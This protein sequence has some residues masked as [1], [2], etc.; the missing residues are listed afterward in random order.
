MRN[1]LSEEP[2]QENEDISTFEPFESE[3]EKD[4]KLSSQNIGL[5]SERDTI[6]Q[7]KDIK[8]SQTEENICHQASIQSLEKIITPEEARAQEGEVVEVT[9][10]E[11]SEQMKSIE[12]DIFDDEAKT[13][14]LVEKVS[15]RDQPQSNITPDIS[16]AGDMP[17]VS[18][19]HADNVAGS[20]NDKETSGQMI[21]DT[22]YCYEKIAETDS[23]TVA[24]QSSSHFEADEIRADDT[25]VERLTDN[26]ADLQYEKE[27]SDQRPSDAEE[28]LESETTTQS[29]ADDAFK[30]EEPKSHITNEKVVADDKKVG[31]DDLTGYEAE[32]LHEKENSDQITFDANDHLESKAKTDSFASNASDVEQPMS[33]ITAD[34]VGADD[35]QVD[36]DE[37]TGH[38]AGSQ[39]DKETL[40][41]MS[42][43]EEDYIQGKAK[44]ENLAENALDIDHTSHIPTDE[45]GANDKQVDHVEFTGNQAGSQDVKETP[46]QMSLNEE[47]YIQGR[48]ITDSLAD[49]ALD[50][51]QITS[52]IAADKVGND[53]KVVGESQV[54]SKEFLASKA[55]SQNDKEKL[56]QMAL[57][58]KENIG[59]K[60]KTESLS[61]HAPD[62]DQPSF[63]IPVNEDRAEEKKDG[64]D[65][66]SVVPDD[67]VGS[68]NYKGKHN[69]MS[70]DEED[71]F[72]SKSE[73]DSLSKNSSAIDLSI[74]H[75]KAN[76]VEDK[77][78]QV[79]IKEV[80][81]NEI[82]DKEAG[83]PNEEQN[84]DETDNQGSL[85]SAGTQNEKE[86]KTEIDNQNIS[87]SIETLTAENQ[88]VTILPTHIDEV[89][90]IGINVEDKATLPQ[91]IGSQEG[92]EKMYSRSE[93]E[94]P[95]DDLNTS[96]IEKGNSNN[97]LRITLVD[98][99]PDPTVGNDNKQDKP[100]VSLETDNHDFSTEKQNDLLLYE[101]I[102]ASE[103]E[104][105][106][107]DQTHHDIDFQGQLTLDTARICQD[108]NITLDLNKS[109]QQEDHSENAKLNLEFDKDMQ[110]LNLTCD[111]TADLST[112]EATESNSKDFS[113][114]LNESEESMVQESQTYQ[115]YD[116]EAMHVDVEPFDLNQ[117]DD[118]EVIQMKPFDK[119]Q[120]DNLEIKNIDDVAHEQLPF[121][122]V[123]KDGSQLEKLSPKL[124]FLDSL[125]PIINSDEFGTTKFLKTDESICQDVVS[126]K[127]YTSDDLQREEITEKSTTE[128]FDWS[129][130]NKDTLTEGEPDENMTKTLDSP[131]KECFENL[132]LLDANQMPPAT[133]QNES[134]VRD[135]TEDVFDEIDGKHPYTQ[136]ED[137]SQVLQYV[138][139]TFSPPGLTDDTCKE[140]AKSPIPRTDNFQEQAILQGL[141]NADSSDVTS[142][143]AYQTKISHANTEQIP[144]ENNLTSHIQRHESISAN[145]NLTNNDNLTSVGS[146]ILIDEAEADQGSKMLV[147][148]STDNEI[149]I[150]DEPCSDKE[151]TEPAV[152]L[153]EIQDTS[154][155]I[156]RSIK[157]KEI[158]KQAS[159]PNESSFADVPLSKH[160]T[161]DI[162]SDPSNLTTSSIV[163][164]SHFQ[165]ENEDEEEI[166]RGQANYIATTSDTENLSK[167]SSNSNNTESDFKNQV[168]QK[169]IEENSE[170]EAKQKDNSENVDQVE[171]E[172][173]YPRTSSTNLSSDETDNTNSTK[174]Q[175]GNIIDDGLKG[176]ANEDGDYSVS[177]QNFESDRD[178]TEDY[179]HCSTLIKPDNF[180]EDDQPEKISST[181]LSYEEKRPEETSAFRELSATEESENVFDQ[182]ENSEFL[183]SK[184]HMG[185]TK[186][187]LDSK[188]DFLDQESQAECVVTSS[189]DIFKEN[190]QETIKENENLDQPNSQKTE[191][192]LLTKSQIQDSSKDLDLQSDAQKT[193]HPDEKTFLEEEESKSSSEMSISNEP[194]SSLAEP[195]CTE[196][197]FKTN[198]H[199]MAHQ[200]SIENVKCRQV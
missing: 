64:S 53:D 159:S 78:K 87:E 149:K 188:S 27:Y 93:G 4:R 177:N 111:E 47:D 142:M 127:I 68:Q 128:K 160:V 26:K 19:E 110:T 14:V 184:S 152:P 196:Q 182:R 118:S 13:H 113:K 82:T 133:E 72:G 143:H 43:N 11:K 69:Q 5:V 65:E 95:S 119:N 100:K 103:N 55:G 44:T 107:S 38:E 79:E 9:E 31:S 109:N 57:N 175:R 145:D 15:Y 129:V 84:A 34:Q 71:P 102:N 114:E 49:N 156:S 122:K 187:P 194:Y 74:P 101:P 193:I 39:D 170:Y 60:A 81:S 54:G 126:A 50:I 62:T 41:Q 130:T 83:S 121:G 51:D 21:S 58:A 7:K 180:E 166:Q 77:N 96:I 198:Y 28:H 174:Y 192:L 63:Q 75:I 197:Q 40:V 45:I 137:N 70:A 155:P 141:D 189:V 20:Q 94:N 108:K 165:T 48:A 73:T 42:L 23:L 61:K 91:K 22:D 18:E 106:Y 17:V 32:L 6:F 171:K 24:D 150:L 135:K 154:D 112:L 59:N 29:F 151:S 105:H 12:E 199:A 131:Q 183:Q 67:E 16:G 181:P 140:S 153:Q 56:H 134:L 76:E 8:E 195:P 164:E 178:T 144:E 136:A 3:A 132:V 172:Q 185:A 104:I 36:H 200:V 10:Q 88:G 46:M 167:Q 125:T 163:D 99:S 90:C 186:I 139:S 138:S 98:E 80:E 117:K 146:D 173:D 35:I 123:E 1:N 168:S 52:H 37:L 147:T 33:H 161:C 169:D 116:S 86:I 120:K 157:N 158:H 85:E 2:K 176:D 92:E 162:A 89:T 115:N 179:M 97:D 191:E 66:L 30:I 190:I 25:Q 124:E 148:E